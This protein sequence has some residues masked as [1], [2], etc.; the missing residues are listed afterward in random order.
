MP[1][2]LPA[3]ALSAPS[4]ARRWTAIAAA[5]LALTA[6][7]TDWA[8]AWDTARGLVPTASERHEWDGADVASAPEVDDPAALVDG[9]DD[10]AGAETARLS[11][12]GLVLDLVW[13]A[14]LAITAVQVET[15]ADAFGTGQRL[16]LAMDSTTAGGVNCL[17]A[18]LATAEDRTTLQTCSRAD[19]HEPLGTETGGGW[20]PDHLFIT[21]TANLDPSSD[22]EPALIDYYGLGLDTGNAYDSGLWGPNGWS[23][24]HD[25]AEPVCDGD[26]G[27]SLRLDDLHLTDRYDDPTGHS[28]GP[29]LTRQS[30]PAFPAEDRLIV[31]ACVPVGNDL[32]DVVA[33][34][35]FPQAAPVPLARWV[36][37]NA[38]KAEAQPLR[39]AVAVDIRSCDAALARCS[40][41]D[42][43]D[44]VND[45]ITNERMSELLA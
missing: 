6:W 1:P 32:R 22:A 10:V 34:D 36:Q 24:D 12:D 33:F 43:N 26:P 30:G 45:G 20:S 4:T 18:S 8:A 7:N 11:A 16:A 5:A 39:T 17:N 40:S 44:P 23:P 9:I 42:N 38:S 19:M 35:P 28:R 3:S 21:Q 14:P 25:F 31:P 15:Y 27:I 37:F 2:L 41:A 29:E 13:E